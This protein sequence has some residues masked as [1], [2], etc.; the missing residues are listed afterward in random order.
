MQ[1]AHGCKFIE[2]AGIFWILAAIISLTL[3]T[4]HTPRFRPTLNLIFGVTVAGLLLMLAVLFYIVYNG[5]RQ[6]IVQTSDQ[7]RKL[8][9][10]RIAARVENFQSVA[11]D[12]IDDIEVQIRMKAVSYQKPEDLEPA[13]YSALLRHPTMNEIA[14]TF[15]QKK[16]VNAKGEVEFEVRDR[17]A[18]R[19]IRVASAGGEHI[20]TR[21]IHQSN[22]GY[23]ED[24]RERP[25]GGDFNS[26]PFT[27]MTGAAPKDPTT[28]DTFT[29]T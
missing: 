3:D 8:A 1:Q 2:N 23:V 10:E 15:A 9:S 12:A 29:E 26:A 25:P 11:E 20:A 5:S 6:A 13:L 21:Y 27:R 4:P 7:V 16:D 28:D 17:G 22:E 14:F 24:A 18:V 19:V